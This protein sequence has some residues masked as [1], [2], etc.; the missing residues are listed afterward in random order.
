MADL[1]AAGLELRLNTHARTI[2][3]VGRT[4]TV[5]TTDGREEQLRYDAL[6]VS[7]GAVPV[8][9]AI[10]GLDALRPDDGV[11]LLHTMGDTFALIR[12]WPATP[13]AL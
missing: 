13:A 4:V 11:H 5:V 3:R 8:R 10:E 12:A 9:P 2:D 1:E 6:V 7:T